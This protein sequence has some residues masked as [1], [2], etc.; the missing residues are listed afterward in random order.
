MHAVRRWAGLAAA[1][2]PALL[3][4]TVA[5]G[6]TAPWRA[7]P[8]PRPATTPATAPAE[9]TQLTPA[10]V[11]AQI[12]AAD[13]LRSRLEAS[14]AA[15][16]AANRRLDQLATRSSGLL[17][18]LAAA[19]DRPLAEQVRGRPGHPGPRRPPRAQPPRPRPRRRPVW[20]G[21]ELRHRGPPVDAAQRAAVRVVPP[22][23]GRAVRLHARAVALGVRRLSPAA[24]CADRC[25]CLWQA[26]AMTSAVD[27]GAP[28]A[29]RR[30]TRHQRVL[31]LVRL[32]QLRL[33]HDHRHGAVL[34]L[35]H[36]GGQGRRV[37]GPA[38]RRGV[39]S[40][41]RRPR[42]PGLPRLP[43]PLHR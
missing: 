3:A 18:R 13:A 43:G 11:T 8:S 35:P 15:V 6:A 19:R 1:V 30:S 28:P 20:R 26:S 29:R 14:S 23:L 24:P 36:L 16:S 12:A 27:S 22:G 25:R 31:V 34:P 38:R 42:G 17:S 40:R 4:A 7:S 10:Q 21:A 9:P 39:P 37:P 41:P 5:G 2:T 33:R 32:G